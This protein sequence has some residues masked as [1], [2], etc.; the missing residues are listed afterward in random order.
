M[1]G[2]VRGYLGVR[3]IILFIAAYFLLRICRFFYS[4]VLKLYYAETENYMDKEEL[5]YTLTL[6]DGRE[7]RLNSV[8]GVLLF[9]EGAV[10]LSLSGGRVEIT[11]ENL[12]IEEL[13]KEQGEILL[14]GRVDS[15]SFEGARDAKGVFAKL[16]K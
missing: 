5:K 11:G 2:N 1:S 14:T 4:F 15:I 10:T 12:K 3:G 8:E 16:F 6:T 7:L 13:T 9:D